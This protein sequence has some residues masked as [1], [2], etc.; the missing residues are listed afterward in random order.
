MTTRLPGGITTLRRLLANR[1]YGL[2]VIGHWVGNIGLWIQRVAIGWLTWELSESSGWL[3]AM[4]VADQAPA[5]AIGIFAGAVVDRVDY[6][7]MLRL[8][9]ALTFVHSVVLAILT[10]G[11]AM[12]IWLLFALTLARGRRA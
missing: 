6:L 9:Q 2:Y 10:L 1:D 12:D 4:A 7:K 3:G 5:I 8:T 11:G